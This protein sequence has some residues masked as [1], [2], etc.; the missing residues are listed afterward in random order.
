MILRR[1]AAADLPT[2]LA[3]RNDPE[4]ARY[5]AWEGCSD[6]EARALFA[7]QERLE[8]GEPGRW[9][10]FAMQL[11]ET[12][13]LV[14]NCALKVGEVLPRQGEI[15][16]TLAREYQRRGLAA[17]AVARVLDYAFGPLGLHRVVAVTDCRN[18]ASAAL[19]ERLGLRREGHFIRNV[20]FKGEWA[21]EYL[22]AVLRDE[23][24][25]RATREGASGSR[26]S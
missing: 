6:E 1:F 26:D 21:D 16:Y 3:Y 12:G 20:W 22:Y 11:K 10:Q 23:W 25:R 18:L 13:E 4:V 24:L 19:L 8:P 7:S 5:Q 2:F 9:F 17:E 15:G 14:G